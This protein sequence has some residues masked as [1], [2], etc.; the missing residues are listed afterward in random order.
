MKL[1][2]LLVLCG[3]T[4]NASA[5]GFEDYLMYQAIVQRNQAQALEREQLEQKQQL[6]ELEA[7]RLQQEQLKAQQAEIEAC[8]QSGR[9]VCF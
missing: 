9:L 7:Q 8:K 3:L 6:L 2:I 4:F 1:V 5:N